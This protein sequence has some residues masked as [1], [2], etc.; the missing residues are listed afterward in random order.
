MTTAAWKTP[1]IERADARALPDGAITLHMRLARN[2][3]ASFTYK[4]P[5]EVAIS[6][7]RALRLALGT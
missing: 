7:D 2:E 3:G 1:T 6:L 4:L 5:R